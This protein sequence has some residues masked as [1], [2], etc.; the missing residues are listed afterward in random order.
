[1]HIYIYAT[2]R[3]RKKEGEEMKRRNEEER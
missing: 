3:E 1:M 2:E